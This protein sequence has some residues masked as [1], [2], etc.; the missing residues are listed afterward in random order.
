MLVHS[1]YPLKSR[2]GSHIGFSGGSRRGLPLPPIVLDQTEA[3]RAE[4]IF[5]RPASSLILG[6]DD[7]SPPPPFPLLSRGSQ[8]LTSSKSLGL[9]AKL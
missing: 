3:R 4:K 6:L 8:N 2:G 9:T 5:W 7:P 1:P